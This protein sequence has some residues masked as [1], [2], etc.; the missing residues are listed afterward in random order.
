MVIPHGWLSLSQKWQGWEYLPEFSGR[1]VAEG[2]SCPS[3]IVTFYGEKPSHGQVCLS[4]FCII[5][6]SW[7]QCHTN[8][9]VLESRSN[10][11]FFIP[12]HQLLKS[13]THFR[14]HI[15]TLIFLYRFF[16]F[17]VFLIAFSL[18]ESKYFPSPRYEWMWASSSYYYME[19]IP[20][21]FLKNMISFLIWIIAF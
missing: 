10:E 15:G 12:L 14:L 6:T 13:I 3:G 20:F 8:K 19:V 7:L 1:A 18:I 9:N 17:L 21:F 4:S 16:L 5:P 11:F 2:M